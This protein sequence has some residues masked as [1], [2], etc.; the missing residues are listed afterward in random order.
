MSPTVAL[1]GC[2]CIVAPGK[3]VTITSGAS[4]KLAY[5]LAVDTTNPLTKMTFEN[6]APLLQI[7]D[8][9]NIGN[10]SVKRNSSSLMRLDYTLWSSPVTNQNILTQ[11]DSPIFFLHQ[12]HLLKQHHPTCIVHIQKLSS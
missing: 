5:N 10:I 6:N 3:S 9:P 12:L 7:N 4:M 1:T 2:N 8:V 11:S